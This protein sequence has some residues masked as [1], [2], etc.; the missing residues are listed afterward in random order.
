[1]LETLLHLF[2]QCPKLAI[3]MS[4]EGSNA[5]F[6]L[7]NRRRYPNLNFSAIATDNPGSN[8]E[9]LAKEFNLAWKCFPEPFKGPENRQK[10]FE[11]IASYLESMQ[12]DA[13]IYSGFMKIAPS[14]FVEKFPGL[15]I[16]P[17]D[18][19]IKDNEGIPLYR[20][21]DAVQMAVENGES[22]L[23]ST[24]H[25]IENRVDCGAPIAVSNPLSISEYSHLSI[26]EIH[27]KLKTE[28]E[29]AL[30]PDTLEILSKETLTARDLPINPSSW[31]LRDSALQK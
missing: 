1:M 16:H 9:S 5:R 19:T 27:D 21:I 24:I 10:R 12:I 28:C 31:Q 11:E 6:L 7:K 4:G 15:N 13:L 25:I 14:F 18:L 22:T 17:A 8:A 26:E 3:L 2:K 20:G 29:H 30:F 23:A